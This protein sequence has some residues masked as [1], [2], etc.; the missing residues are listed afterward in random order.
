MLSSS[1]LFFYT[2]FEFKSSFPSFVHAILVQETEL[3]ETLATLA[4]LRG[5]RVDVVATD[6]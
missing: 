3:H 6:E 2:K 1:K 5:R 4:A